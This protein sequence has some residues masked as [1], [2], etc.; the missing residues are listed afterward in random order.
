MSL[1]IGRLYSA[2]SPAR[3]EFHPLN[4]RRPGKFAPNAL[5]LRNARLHR[6]RTDPPGLDPAERELQVPVVCEPGVHQ[7]DFRERP[8]LPAGSS[9]LRLKLVPEWRLEG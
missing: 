8:P 5:R 3:G 4:P 9:S 7:D 6:R 1:Q 2:T